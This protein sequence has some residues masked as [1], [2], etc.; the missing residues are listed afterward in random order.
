MVPTPG[1][2]QRFSLQNLAIDEISNPVLF[3]A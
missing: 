3:A 1:Q 2:G